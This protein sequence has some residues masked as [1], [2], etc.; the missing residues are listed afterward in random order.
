MEDSSFSVSLFS[1]FACSLSIIR[2]WNGYYW[3]KL[4]NDIG[5]EWMLVCCSLMH[6]RF[7]DCGQHELWNNAYMLDIT[8][9]QLSRMQEITRPPR[10]LTRMRENQLWSPVDRQEIEREKS[11][12]SSI[13]QAV[14]NFYR[15][16]TFGTESNFSTLKNVCLSALDLAFCID[17]VIQLI[18]INVLMIL[19]RF[20]NKESA[21]R[22]YFA[23]DKSSLEWVSAYYWQRR[24]LHEEVYFGGSP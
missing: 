9:S 3:K 1:F 10:E 5:Q 14:V 11:R 17:N 4:I 2:K 6:A 15:R 23:S 7:F 13:F 21:L 8:W 24:L 16:K 18:K 12:R 22:T 19:T 20:Y